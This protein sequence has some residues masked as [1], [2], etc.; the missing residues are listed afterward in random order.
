M[1]G[2]IDYPF[3]VHDSSNDIYDMNR[4][5]GTTITKMGPGSGHGYIKASNAG[6]MVLGL[7]VLVATLFLVAY[8][9]KFKHELK[10][11][12]RK[13]S[14]IYYV[15]IFMKFFTLPLPYVVKFHLLETSSYVIIKMPPKVH[16]L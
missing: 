16:F 10:K 8:K 12:S 3:I 2:T 15:I 13:G 14:S 5:V 9:T 1:N 6:F 4:S 11:I 7:I